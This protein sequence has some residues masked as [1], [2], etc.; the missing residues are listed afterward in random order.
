MDFSRVFFQT[1]VLQ[2]VRLLTGVC[3]AKLIAS[4]LGPA[5]IGIFSQAQSLQSLIMA[6]GSLSLATGYVQRTRYLSDRYSEHYR[7]EIHGTV[8]YT[9]LGTLLPLA[10]ALFFFLPWIE[11]KTFSGSVESGFSTFILWSVPLLS[12]SQMYFEPRLMAGDKYAAY[13]KATCSASIIGVGLL[14]ILLQY[15]GPSALALFLFGSSALSCFFMAAFTYFHFGTQALLPKGWRW[16]HLRP[17]LKISVVLVVTGIAFYGTA[18][19]LRALVLEHLGATY[20]GLIQVPIVM[21]GYY[22]P[23]LT[24]VIWNIYHVRLSEAPSIEKAGQVLSAS[25]KFVMLVQPLIALWIMAFPGIAVGI[26]YTDE[27]RHGIKTF[28]LQ[29]IGDYFYFLLTLLSVM[30]LAQNR[31]R[32]YAALWLTFSL[33]EAASGAFFLLELKLVLRSLAAAHL[34]AAG[35]TFALFFWAG[36]GKNL[37]ATP[38]DFRFIPLAFFLGFGFLLAQS[39]LL[40]SDSD[41]PLRLLCACAYTAILGGM[42]WKLR[43]SSGSSKWKDIFVGKT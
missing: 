1:A 32:L 3:R 16:S 28:P 18:V 27:F 6:V 17:I 31:I 33:I 35:S 38:F 9:L 4:S 25:F 20:A 5:G 10:L 11:A 14:W 41:L 15:T 24:H 36:L 37:K 13:I 12:I 23:L 8:F 21:S 34:I 30:I 29:F 40:R 42:L 7:Q 2:G 19:W 43:S 39:L 26:V 22:S